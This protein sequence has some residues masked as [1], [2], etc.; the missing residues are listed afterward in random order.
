[1]QWSKWAFLAVAIS[2]SCVWA[3]ESSVG[4]DRSS[5]STSSESASKIIDAI[6]QKK[7]EED[8]RINDLQIRAD[9][10]SLSRYSAKFTLGYAGPS[11]NDL[12]QPNIPNPDGRTGDFRSYVSGIVGVKYRLT[13]NDGLY[14]SGGVKTYISAKTGDNQD[15]TDPGITYDHTFLFSRSVQARTSVFGNMVTNSVYR[16][17]GETNGMGVSQYVKWTINDSRWIVGGEVDFNNYIFNRGYDPKDH[18]I[19]DYYFNV[20][21]SVEY[22][23]TSNLNLNTSVLKKLNHYRVQDTATTFDVTSNLLSQRVGVGW[24]VMH[25]IYLNPYVAFFPE[26]MTWANASVGFNGIVSV[27]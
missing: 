23:L 20:I 2:S 18:L 15:I 7:F 4:L 6:K 12:S 13:S 9:A 27:F 1:M 22:K 24:A 21:P 3:E 26:A 25:D 11:L 10:G 14:F 5:A 16:G 17:Y 8:T 19:T